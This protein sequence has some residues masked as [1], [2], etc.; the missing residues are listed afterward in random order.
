L[1]KT[2]LSFHVFSQYFSISSYTVKYLFNIMVKL[3]KVLETQA[4]RGCNGTGFSIHGLRCSACSG[5]GE[6]Q[7]ETL[8]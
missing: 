1:E 7:V 3:V 8:R 5:S 4:C 2:G 6:V